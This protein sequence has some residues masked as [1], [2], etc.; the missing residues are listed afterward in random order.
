MT[1]A[2]AVALE[3]G[4]T[5]WTIDAATKAY[6]FYRFKEVGTVGWSIVTYGGD[7]GIPLEDK[8]IPEADLH[9]HTKPTAPATKTLA[10]RGR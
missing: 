8:E 5:V 10:K 2:E 4:T 9:V 6:R 3:P 7:Y 1:R